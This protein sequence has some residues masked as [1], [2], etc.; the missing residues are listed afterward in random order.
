V[1]AGHDLTLE[2][3]AALRAVV[4]IDEVSIGHHVTIDALHMG[5]TAALAAYMHACR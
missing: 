4:E 5:W 3:L 2:N 1:N